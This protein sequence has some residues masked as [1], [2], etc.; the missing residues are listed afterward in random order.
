MYNNGIYHIFRIH[1][2]ITILVVQCMQKST[3]AMVLLLSLLT[4]CKVSLLWTLHYTNKKIKINKRIQIAF[5]HLQ[6]CLMCTIP[7]LS[8]TQFHEPNPSM[9]DNKAS[10]LTIRCNGDLNALLTETNKCFCMLTVKANISISMI[11]TMPGEALQPIISSGNL[12]HFVSH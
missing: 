7:A 11:I 8:S 9:K 4:I 3:H 6:T 12:I 5:C 1:I 2:T 10:A